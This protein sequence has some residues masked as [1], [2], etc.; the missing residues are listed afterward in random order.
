[1]MGKN[2][3]ARAPE[4]VGRVVCDPEVLGGKATIA[5]TRISVELLL[6]NLS[7][8]WTIPQVLE[9][10]GLDEAD[11]RAAFAF[12]ARALWGYREYAAPSGAE[13]APAAAG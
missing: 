6:E 4:L 1:M 12:A 3:R 5:G 13:S 11:L 9:E 7:G 10:Y 2:P 8:G